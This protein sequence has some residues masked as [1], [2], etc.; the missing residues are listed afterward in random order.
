MGNNASNLDSVDIRPGVMI[1]SV[2]RHLNYKPWFALA[3]FVDNAIQSFLS[4]EARIRQTDGNGAKLRVDIELDLTGE[5]K[6]SI[7]D[8]AAGISS[9]DYPRAFRPAAIPTN[10]KGLSEFGMGMKSAACWFAPRWSVRT[11]ALGEDVER[12]IRFDIDRIVG[13]NLDALGVEAKPA[14]KE[15]H[16]TE[17][18]L[19]GLH[20]VPQTK[21]LGKIREHLSDIFRGF[22]RE[23]V[24]ELQFNG[25]VLAYE[26]PDI[27]EASFFRTPHGPSK[28]WKKDI[29][30]DFGEGMKVTGFAAIRAVGSLS[31]AGF[32]LFRRGRLIQ[33]SGDE[34]YRPELI[35]GKSNSYRYQRIFGELHLEGFDV[36]HTKDGF[37]WDENE[38]PFLQ[39]LKD[40]LDSKALPLLQQAD[41]LRVRPKRT[42]LKAGARTAAQRTAAAVGAA[43]TSALPGLA[44]ASSSN[45]GEDVPSELV[46]ASIVAQEVV[47]E[48]LFRGQKWTVTIE[49][50][51]DPAVSDWLTVTDKTS[52]ASRQIGLRLSLV[53]PFMERFG[54][55]TVEE[56]EPL[57]RVA[58]A[59]GLS[60]TICRDAGIK[61]AGRIRDNINELLRDALAQP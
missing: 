32:A 57:L 60:E 9:K 13:R 61:K 52:S 15:S 47:K 1:L 21:T 18:V 42:D 40:H 46:T 29:D 28:L 50:S 17:V 3:E 37:R 56:I 43:V 54:G 58:A 14:K 7:R 38:Q 41:G 8:N 36:S 39:I 16:F 48:V 20:Q 44:A 53:H 5:P 25:E 10:R 22:I 45:N 35:F 24:L 6:L 2:L 34:G 19:Q 12:T 23:D 31:R 55:T 27:L 51:D 4:N 33:G 30:F 59:L 26:E 49:M 11:S